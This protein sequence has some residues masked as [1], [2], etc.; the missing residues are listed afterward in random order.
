MCVCLCDFL[1]IMYC[2]AAIVCVGVCY[3]LLICC[4]VVVS[5]CVCL[6]YCLL[7]YCRVVVFVS[8]PKEVSI[9][10]MSLSMD[11]GMPG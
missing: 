4:C 9:V 1:S 2:C 5:V 11:F 7:L 10:R 6:C 3:V 8:K